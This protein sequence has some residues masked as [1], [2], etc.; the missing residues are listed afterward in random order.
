[1]EI[2]FWVAGSLVVGTAFGW[3]LREQH[4]IRVVN[5]MFENA[6]KELAEKVGDN[7]IKAKLEVHH[8]HFYM[9][10]Q[11]TDAFLAQGETAEELSA[12]LREKFPKVVFIL[13]KEAY[14]KLGVSH[15]SI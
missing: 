1:M 12:M 5:K 8:G 2:V 11:E 6:E 4:A 10:N 3:F 15:E 7:T 9:F 14:G 13:P